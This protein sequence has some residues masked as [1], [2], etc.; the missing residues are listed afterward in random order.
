M[1]KKEK[2]KIIFTEIKS[3]S[4]TNNWRFKSYFVYKI[5]NDFL[6]SIF[7]FPDVKRMKLWGWICFKPNGV[8]DIF[9]EVIGEKRNIEFPLSY[10]IDCATNIYPITLK[11]FEIEINFE[12]TNKQIEDLFENLENVVKDTANKYQ[13]INDYI[14]LL[15]SQPKLDTT[16]LLTCLLMLGNFKAVLNKIEKLKSED[17]SPGFSYILDDKVNYYT[18]VEDYC[19]VK[20][21]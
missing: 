16:N 18:L 19:Q 20:S 12:D 4:K 9:W 7:L 10:R 2:E 1:T 11:E 6:Y 13:T 8:D 5:K 21:R 17:I 15:I 14:T 3:I